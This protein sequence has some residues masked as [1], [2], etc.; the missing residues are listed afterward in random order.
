MQS[1]SLLTT[2]IINGEENK[3]INI[4]KILINSAKQG[5]TVLVKNI[6]EKKADVNYRES[7]FTALHYAVKNDH[8]HLVHDLVFDGFDFSPASFKKLLQDI[9]EP[10]DDENEERLLFLLHELIDYN[11]IKPTSSLL[12]MMEDAFSFSLL[13]RLFSKKNSSFTEISDKLMPHMEEYVEFF[14][15]RKKQ[16]SEPAYLIKARPEWIRLSYE[17][18]RDLDTYTELKAL[19]ER[20]E[21]QLDESDLQ[22]AQYYLNILTYIQELLAPDRGYSKDIIIPYLLSFLPKVLAN[23]TSEYCET[24]V[25]DKW[26]FFSYAFPDKDEDSEKLGAEVVAKEML[27]L[28]QKSIG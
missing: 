4:N 15:E 17:D 16:L 23:I 7:G 13:V 12:T 24:L 5:S 9:T 28:K 26:R 20:K 22:D 3:Q 1:Q 18:G 21:N 27:I 11:K 25:N 14:S 10:G 8:F 19:C 6:L 2:A